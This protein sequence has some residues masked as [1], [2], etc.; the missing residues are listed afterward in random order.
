MGEICTW[1]FFLRKGLHPERGQNSDKNVHKKGNNTRNCCHTTI[2]E[3]LLTFLRHKI[4]TLSWKENT[5]NILYTL[6]KLNVH[7]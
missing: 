6:D 5:R 4:L 2:E 3:K 7:I 1:T